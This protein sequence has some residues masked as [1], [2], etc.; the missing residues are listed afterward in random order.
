MCF[1][2]WSEGPFGRSTNSIAGNVLGIVGNADEVGDMDFDSLSECSYARSDSAAS[3][4]PAGASDLVDEVSHTSTDRGSAIYKSEY[5]VAEESFVALEERW[6]NEVDPLRKEK[7]QKAVFEAEVAF[8]LRFAIYREIVV[9]NQEEEAQAKVRTRNRMRT[10]VQ[11]NRCVGVPEKGRAS[12]RARIRRA[13]R[14]RVDPVT[15]QIISWAA[16]QRQHNRTTYQER[17][18]LWRELPRVRRRAKNRLWAG[19]SMTW[20]QCVERYRDFY[21]MSVLYVW[22]V[23]L[24]RD[25]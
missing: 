5:E 25:R 22:F 9:G 2:G 20:S 18:R 21:D 16:F 12:K 4:D 23:E 1:G 7:L 13:P 6:L 11:D 19:H 8:A 10:R 14:S 24:P 3:A 15:R 17:I